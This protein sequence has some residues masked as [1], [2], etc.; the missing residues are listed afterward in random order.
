MTTCIRR[1]T[2]SSV[3]ISESLLPLPRARDPPIVFASSTGNEPGTGFECPCLERKQPR[4]LMTARVRRPVTS[5]DIVSPKLTEKQ[6]LYRNWTNQ[7][8][9]RYEFCYT[10][11]HTRILR[12]TIS[13]P[14]IK[15]LNRELKILNAVVV[16]KNTDQRRLLER[17]HKAMPPPRHFILYFN[18]FRYTSIIRILNMGMTI[19]YA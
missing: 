9:P 12:T 10:D 15:R 17:E 18:V 7:I 1:Y 5:I 4:K 6:N 11:V 2:R 8:S 19:E 14:A 3:G 13:W 16:K